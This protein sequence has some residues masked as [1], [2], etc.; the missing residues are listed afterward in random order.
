MHGYNIFF[1]RF[2]LLS[3]YKKRL[4]VSDHFTVILSKKSDTSQHLKAQRSS[5]QISALLV[6]GNL[7]TDKNAIC[8]MWAD[9]FEVLGSPSENS[10]FDNDFFSRVTQCS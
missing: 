7:L 4:K 8:D 2:L 3:I 6:N 10:N 5:S 9:H 1:P